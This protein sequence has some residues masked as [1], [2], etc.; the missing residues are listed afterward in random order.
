LTMQAPLKIIF[1]VGGT[2]G[3]LFPAVAIAQEFMDRNSSNHIIFLG[4]GKPLENSVLSEYGFDSRKIS[5]EGIKGRGLFR[6][7]RGL[8]IM[9]RGFFQSVRILK[10]EKPDLVIGMGS[11][12]AVPVVLAALFNRIPIVL[13]EQNVLPGIANRYLSVFADRV[14]LS[15]QG[16][17]GNFPETKRRFTGNP[18]RIEILQ[19]AAKKND[20]QGPFS[21]LILGGSQGAHGINMAA[22]EALKI[23]K[24]SGHF[25]FIHQTGENDENRV[26]KAYKENDVSAEV[27]AFFKDIARAYRR[28]DLVVCRAGATTVAEVSALGKPAIFIP[29][30]HAS[31]D[32]Q[33]INARNLVD[34]GA[35]DLIFEKDLTG[36]LLAEKILNLAKNQRRLKKMAKISASLGRPNAAKK[37]VE[38]CVELVRKKQRES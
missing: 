9:G 23:F 29:F 38:E 11:Y 21:I 15:F 26:R 6:Q 33:V 19:A 24:E 16:T 7:I 35:S 28:A 34:A 5:A 14:C 25:F 1:A 30:P 20:I 3:H 22:I 8:L 13:C 32:H 4:Q 18:V 31:D 2:G 12:S 37:I 36:E 10:S 17:L 27:K